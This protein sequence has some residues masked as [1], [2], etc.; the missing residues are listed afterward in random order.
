MMVEN[1]LRLQ[2]LVHISAGCGRRFGVKSE[3][4]VNA[5]G[6]IQ[7]DKSNEVLADELICLTAACVLLHRCRWL[8]DVGT[9]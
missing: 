3:W 4:P 2:K 7:V 6:C 5:R 9:W 8:L 1:A